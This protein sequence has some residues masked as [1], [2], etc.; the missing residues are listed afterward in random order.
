[1]RRP[2]ARRLEVGPN[3]ERG[4]RVEG[5]VQMGGVVYPRQPQP[6]GGRPRDS[7]AR[8]S[9]GKPLRLRCVGWKGGARVVRVAA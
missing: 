5:F 8:Y 9:L 4:F 1:V 7:G 6:T 3:P 2:R